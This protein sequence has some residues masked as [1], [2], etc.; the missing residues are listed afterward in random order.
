[1]QHIVTSLSYSKSRP[2]NHLNWERIFVVENA[3]VIGNVGYI[4]ARV[5][6]ELIDHVLR[7]AFCGDW[8]ELT[9]DWVQRGAF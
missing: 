2:E 5:E 9:Q 3:Q 7:L 4:S 6:Q 8:T 1:M